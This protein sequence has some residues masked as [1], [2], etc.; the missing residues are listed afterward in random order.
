MLMEFIPSIIQRLRTFALLSEKGMS[1]P[2]SG[3]NSNGTLNRL[4]TS[5]TLVYINRNNRKYNYL[6]DLLQG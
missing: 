2:N 5:C 3:L 1:N 4:L 6:I